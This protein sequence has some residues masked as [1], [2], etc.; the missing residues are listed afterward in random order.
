[1][2]MSLIGW[3]WLDGLIHSD[4]AGKWPSPSFGKAGSPTPGN[5]TA[6][7]NQYTNDKGPVFYELRGRKV[8]QEEDSREETGQ[9]DSD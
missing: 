3:R 5:F 9:V 6:W 2:R 8:L 7:V 1:M 4:Q